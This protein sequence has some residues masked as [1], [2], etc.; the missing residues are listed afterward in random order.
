MNQNKSLTTTSSETFGFSEEAYQ[1]I[2]TSVAQKATPV[3]LKYFLIQCQR[4]GLDPIT[5]QIYFIKGNDGKVQIQTSID[6]FRLIAERSGV[7]EGQT[8]AQWCGKDGNWKDVWLSEDYPAAAKIGVYKKGFRE[9][10][11]AV[12]IFDECAQR[13]GDGS[14]N[15]M[16][17]KMPALMLA[18][19]A[20]SLA[21]RKSFPNEM[22]GLYTQEEMGTETSDEP[23]EPKF[24]SPVKI[25]TVVSAPVAQAPNQ[26]TPKPVIVS[27]PVQQNMH[28]S[29][30]DLSGAGKARQIVEKLAHGK[31]TQFDAQLDVLG[32]PMEQP[33]Y[34]PAYDPQSWENQE[35]GYG[36]PTETRDVYR[37]DFGKFKGKTLVEIGR[38][39]DGYASYLLDSARTRGKEMSPS[40][41]RF[42]D[43]LDRAKASVK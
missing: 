5:R 40:V 10:L 38:D 25:P 21:L 22:S 27:P 4:T 33:P 17:N 6:G 12:A 24:K 1:V 43:E 18:K 19:V 16:W 2:Q 13:K 36:F 34:D 14:L 31:P 9:A 41:K 37:V 8:Q 28:E 32:N 23:K 39:V 15:Y 26:P 3:E 35:P 20:E 7:Y 30:P 11:Y 29:G 42:L